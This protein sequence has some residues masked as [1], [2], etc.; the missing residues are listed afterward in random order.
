MVSIE[1]PE[2]YLDSLRNL[3]AEAAMNPAKTLFARL[4]CRE[5]LRDNALRDWRIYVEFAQRL[6]TQVRKLYAGESL[7]F[8]LTNTTYA[9]D[10]T[11]VD[12]PLSLSLGCRSA[13]PE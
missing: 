9:L 1:T 7:G 8:D 10:S 6:I 11:T 12:L 4:I 5:S 3:H 2:R 13:R